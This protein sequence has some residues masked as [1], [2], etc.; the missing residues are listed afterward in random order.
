M[1]TVTL[2]SLSLHIPVLE[3]REPTDLHAEAAGLS[4]GPNA[5][6]LVNKYLD[7]DESFAIPSP[8]S[9]ILGPAGAV[10][11]EIPATFWRGLRIEPASK[12]RGSNAPAR[13]RKRPS[14]SFVRKEPTEQKIHFSAPLVIAADGA[15]SALR[16]QLQPAITSEYAGYVAWR[17]CIPEAQTPEPLKGALEGK[18]VFT[19]LGGHYIIAYLTPGPTGSTKQGDRVFEWCW[20]SPSPAGSPSFAE[21]MTDTVGHRHNKTVP[22]GQLRDEVFHELIHKSKDPFVTAITSHRGSAS[23]FYNGKVFLAGEAYTQFRPHLG[24]SCDLAVLQALTLREALTGDKTMA[25]YE[26]AVGDYAAEFSMRS[27]AMD[28]F[29]LTGKWPEGYVPLYAK[30][31]T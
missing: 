12:R 2:Q 6:T 31:P 11:A 7:T 15:R 10:I 20:Y 8:G 22:R 19:M 30:K 23:T 27:T 14:E 25:E 17:G 29:G 1:H 28:H 13:K 24:L 3:S 26:K 4:M 5:Q 18:L 21:I 9:Q 16:A